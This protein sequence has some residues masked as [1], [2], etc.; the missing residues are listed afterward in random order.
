MMVQNTFDFNESCDYI[1]IVRPFYMNQNF[2]T[3]SQLLAQ[4]YKQVQKKK[5]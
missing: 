4:L 1:V 3:N 2:E 5:G